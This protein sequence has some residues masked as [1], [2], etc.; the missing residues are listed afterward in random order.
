MATIQQ[1][2]DNSGDKP[3]KGG[4]KHKKSKANKGR[5]TIHGIGENPTQHDTVNLR[6][7][8]QEPKDP[9]KPSGQSLPDGPDDSDDDNYLP[10]D[11]VEDSLEAKDF[12]VPDDPEESLLIFYVPVLILLL[13][14][15]VYCW[16]RKLLALADYAFLLTPDFIEVGYYYFFSSQVRRSIVYGEQLINMLD[17]YITKDNIR[18]CSV[19]A[20]VTGGAWISGY[21]AWGALLGR[22]LAERGIIVACIDYINYPEGTISDMVSD[23]SEGISFVCNNIASSGGDPNEIYLMGQL[24]RA[25]ISACVLMEHAAMMTF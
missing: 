23:A 18:P 11:D 2:N 21:K 20:F 24:A 12:M 13:F 19:V 7:P 17:L 15:L 16:M 22:R 9:N 8:E 14:G 3:S 6:A 10:P 4:K 1:D 5:W 25:H